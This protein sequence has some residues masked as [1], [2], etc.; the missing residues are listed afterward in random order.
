[1]TEVDQ[2]EI[3]TLVETQLLIRTLYT[4]QQEQVLLQ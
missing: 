4:H 3:A 2:Y 1:M